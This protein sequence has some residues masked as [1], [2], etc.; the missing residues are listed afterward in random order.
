MSH[1]RQQIRDVAFAN[2]SGLVTTGS[3]VYKSR[4]Y[5][6]QDE[7]L[8]GLCVYTSAEDNDDEQGKFD[9]IDIRTLIIRV[10]AYDKVI[11]GV[12]DSLDTMALEVETAILA[13][14]K[15][16][17]IA[18]STDYMGF[19]SETS[20]DG[21]QPVGKASISFRVQYFVNTGSPGTAV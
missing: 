17:G 15:F 9:V 10:D 19:E 3:R 21:E 8:P 16:G 1:V 5:P 4:A 13:D 12:E 7:E 2:L 20:T 11:G 14:P 6:L 18:K